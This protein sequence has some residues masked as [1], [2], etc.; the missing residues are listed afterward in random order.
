MTPETLDTWDEIRGLMSEGA[1]DEAIEAYL[2]TLEPGDLVRTIFRLTPDEQRSLL[3]AVSPE[4]AAELIEDLP[5]THA[6][7]LIDDMPAHQAAAI[8]EEMA[9]DDRADLLAE[10]G[11]PEAEAILEHLD[12]E[13]ADEARRLISYPANTAGGLMM[14][15][16]AVYPMRATVR[17]VVEDLTSREGDYTFL[18]VHYVYVVV[19]RHVLKGVLRLRDMVFA[20]PDARIGDIAKPAETVRPEATLGE[21]DEFFDENDIAAVPVVDE[22]G[23]L[24]GIVRRRAVLEALAEKAETDSLKS[25]GIVG[26]EE[27]RSMPV[28]LRSRRRLGWLSINIV[29]NI[30]AASVIALYED[31]LSAVIALAVFLPIVSDMSGCSGNQ[32]VAVSMRE[33]TL[34]AIVPRD[35]FRVWGKEISVGVINGLTLGALLAVAAWAWKGS[36]LLGLVVGAALALNTIVA[37]S[38][39]GTIPLALRRFG[40]DPAVASGP[41]LTTVTDMCGF[42]LVLSLA[43]LALPLLS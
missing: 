21:L 4:R 16:F 27:L 18:T 37:V 13:D 12:E 20:D 41:V 2:D 40:V 24:L 19:K 9:S 42:F 39:G 29:L 34:G 28:I 33:L 6:A 31:T 22:R 8:V 10:M 23:L 3:T 32:A 7:D 43:S 14:T 35:L 11:E 26:G 1:T 15:E 38:L 5:D 30:I 36:P 25:A 17:E